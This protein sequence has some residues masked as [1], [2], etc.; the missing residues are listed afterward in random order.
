VRKS[1]IIGNYNSID[2]LPRIPATKLNMPGTYISPVKSLQ[3]SL[4]NYIP[5]FSRSVS[6]TSGRSYT[7]SSSSG[8]SGRSITRSSSGSSSGRSIRSR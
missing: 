5:G 1:S 7:G 3:N 6:S 8:S 4:T 2:I